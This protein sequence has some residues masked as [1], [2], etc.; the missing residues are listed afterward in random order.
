MNSVR[1]LK[2]KSSFENSSADKTANRYT[3]QING[4]DEIEKF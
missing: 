1:L 4:Y 2:F 3:R